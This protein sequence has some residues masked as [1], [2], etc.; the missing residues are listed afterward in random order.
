MEG[1][2]MELNGVANIKIL[3]DM[4]V[5]TNETTGLKEVGLYGSEVDAI[6]QQLEM[7]ER[8][9]IAVEKQIGSNN[10][11]LP[12]WHEVLANPSKFPRR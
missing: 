3:I 6:Y 4:N 2:N 7:L 1:N 10:L 5:T 8:Y 9:M 11:D 12:K